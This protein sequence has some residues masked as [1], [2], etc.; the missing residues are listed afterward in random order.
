VLVRVSDSVKWVIQFPG[1]LADKSNR[2]RRCSQ[3]KSANLMKFQPVVLLT[4]LLVA[5]PALACTRPAVPDSIPD[6]KTATREVMLAKK[7]EVDQYRREVEI[8]LAC[9]SN[10]VRLRS[11]QG[12][13]DRVAAR[14]NAE[15]RAFKAANGD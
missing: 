13:L 6:G 4:A 11:A 10:L 8:Y 9:E 7:K 2:T 5:G 1:E 15:V 3:S 12:E 14:F